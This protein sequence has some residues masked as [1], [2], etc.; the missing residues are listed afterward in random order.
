[1]K[2]KRILLKISGEAFAHANGRGINFDRVNEL[3]DEIA[4]LHTMG[5]AIAIVMG[6]GN[7]WRYRDFKNADLTREASDYTGMM[8]T[9]LNAL[10]L[11]DTLKNTDI[12]VDTFSAFGIGS[13]VTQYKITQ[14]LT[15]LQEGNVVLL[16]GGTGAPYVT[17]DTAAAMR[18][19]ELECDA[20][21]KAT[22]VDGVYSAD[23]EEDPNATRFETLT[24]TEA[25]EKE[26]KVMDQDAFSLCAE[27]NIPIVVFRFKKGNIV[28][29]V[30]GEEIGTVV[31]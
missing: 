12:P 1:M 11:A 14:A 4:E 31:N 15:S 19:S 5:I 20:L 9:I 18:A 24:Y 21:L 16:G 22:K 17:T 30:R 8:A 10:V 26:L 2:Y 13:I 3:V 27:N 28:K 29:V 7:F 23:P 6:G 25:T